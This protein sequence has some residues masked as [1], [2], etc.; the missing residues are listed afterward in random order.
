M[1]NAEK[2]DLEDLVFKVQLPYSQFENILDIKR[3]AT[4]TTG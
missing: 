4:S 1:K 3:I 2:K